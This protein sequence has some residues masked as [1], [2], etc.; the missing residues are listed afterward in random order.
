MLQIVCYLISGSNGER[1]SLEAKKR[2]LEHG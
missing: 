2:V 1:L